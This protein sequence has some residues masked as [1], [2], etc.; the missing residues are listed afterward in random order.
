MEQKICLSI[1]TPTYNRAHLLPTLY[2]SLVQQTSHAFEWV[3]ID[4][5]STDNTEAV[6]KDFPDTPFPI[7]YRRKENGGKCRALNDV[8]P[9][10]RGETTIIVDS[11]DQLTPDAC[12]TILSDVKKCF[13]NPDIGILSYRRGGVC[14]ETVSK[15]AE[16]ISDF[17]L[18]DEI[19]FRVN[20]GIGGDRAEVI[21]TGLLQAYPFPAFPDEN[22]MSE[23]WLWNH[24]AE[25]GIKAV[26]RKKTIYLC[27]YLEG[28]LT[29]S[30]RA[31][32]MRN[33]MGMMEN[34]KAFFHPEVKTSVQ[35]KEMLLYCVY[36]LCAKQ[37]LH[38][39]IQRSGRPWL[40][41]LTMPAGWLL[42]AFWKHRY[43]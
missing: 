26:Y 39:S 31:L 22:F 11:D 37:P 32:R 38:T 15:E 29:K 42:Y 17:Y 43:L 35:I 25:D 5:G 3:I 20:Q 28:G 30:G 34:C 41:R 23:G 12:E 27:E 21:R 10:L 7:V 36:A 40:I 4:D 13:C 14:G 2:Q 16:G 33:P 24:L 1:V 8:A 19:H 18:G 9:Y 6:V